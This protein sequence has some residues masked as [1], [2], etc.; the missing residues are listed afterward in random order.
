[1]LTRKF[2]LL[3]PRGKPTKSN[4]K[5]Q[6]NLITRKLGNLDWLV[7]GEFN[8]NQTQKIRLPKINNA[9]TFTIVLV[10]DTRNNHG[11]FRR[12]F[13]PFFLQTSIHYDELLGIDIEDT[14]TTFPSAN[15]KSKG[16]VML[17]VSLSLFE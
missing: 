6:A 16:F 5:R 11:F 14:M 8:Q 2:G 9:N 1:M 12:S 13:F 17:V 15:S 10:I 3:N 4:I 7:P